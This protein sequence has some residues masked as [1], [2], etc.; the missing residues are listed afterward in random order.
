[1]NIAAVLLAPGAGSDANHRTLVALGEALAPLPV[2]RMDFPYRKAGRKLP[3]RTPILVGAVAA[4]AATLAADTGVAPA[5][6]LLGGRSLGGRMCSL[7]VA[8]GLS[9]AGLVLISYPLH[10]PGKPDRLRVEHF[11]ELGVPC[12][13]VSGSRDTF[14][15]PEELLGHTTAIAGPVAHHW[16][17]GGRHDL[18][19]VADDAAICAAVTAWIAATA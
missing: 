9:A 15:T 17:E 10:P 11:P 5:R 14:A 2:R 1:M 13:F 8:A 12:L 6:I 3:D 18:G 7:A 4:E 19:R 16:L